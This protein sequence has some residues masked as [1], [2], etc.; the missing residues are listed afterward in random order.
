MK[1]SDKFVSEDF[2]RSTYVKHVAAPLFRKSFNLNGNADTAELVICG[3][4]LY[5]LFVNGQRI[6]E[7]RLA[8][9]ISN[10]DHLIYYNRYDLTQYL[11]EGENVI[12]IMLGD[13][14]QNGKTRVWNFDNNIFNSA[15]KLALW[16]SVTAK[17]K[18][19]VFEADS[20]MCKKG[21]VTFNDIRSGI[22]Y[23]KRLEEE[24]WNSPGYTED[25]GWHSPLLADKPR[26]KA[27]L[28]EAEP[29][30]VTKEL[31]P[32]RIFK[33]GIKKYIPVEQVSEGLEGHITEE[34]APAATG[35]WIYDFGE[36]NAGIFR[37]RIHAAPGQRIDIQCSELIEENCLDYSNIYFFPEGYVQRDIYIA[38]GEG[39]EVYEPMFVYHGFRYLYVSGITEEQATEDLLTYLVMSSDLE[40]RGNFECSD[41][42]SNKI[43]EICRRSDISNFY[44]FPNDCPHREKNGWTGDAAASAEH[45]IMTLGAENSWREWMNNI[46]YSQTIAGD[47]PGIVPTDT[48]GYAWGNG[49]SWD[50][51]I[52]ELPYMVYKY[53]GDAGMIEENAHMMLSY[54][55]YISKK[56][57]EKGIV[58]IGLGD[59]VPAN[60]TMSDYIVP[61]GFTDSVMVYD[62]CRQAE[63]MFQAV[64]YHLHALFAKQLG[65]EMLKAVRSEYIDFNTMTVQSRCQTAQAMAIYYDIF[66]PSEKQA[67]F[68][69]LKSIIHLDEEKITVGF[70]G[71][72]VLFHVLAQF[73]EAELAYKMITRSDELSYG[74][75][76][77]DGETTMI[78]QL[79][80]PERRGKISHNHHFLCD[81]VQWYMRYPG[82]IHVVSVD[83]VKIKPVF[84]R[85]LT[86]VK[87]CHELPSGEVR[88]SWSRT[89]TEIKLCV[90]VPQGIKCTVELDA[91]YI[92]GDIKKSYREASGEGEYAV[93]LTK[94]TKN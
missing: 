40:N 48:F 14:F 28:R 94:K 10:S 50:K 43:Y 29:I 82:G 1:F 32:I 33:G 61:L 31:K 67:A 70:L 69:V 55:E 73:G 62:M 52:F 75:L 78:E 42:L 15:P 74:S 49:P 5:E 25:V 80:A 39:E 24:G 41:E 89:E 51:V 86:Y 17:G 36:N 46:R 79:C 63:E 91:G 6:T 18:T 8:P 68:E 13:G 57:D 21:P 54:L 84:L 92:F 7:S 16:C 60:R 53:R 58:A 76:V 34:T 38:N 47:I 35:G 9:Y 90:R 72:R 23:D 22:F 83:C 30:A 87:A 71:M 77:L 37:L 27:K 12:G 2:M 56:R 64:G 45:M 4:G 85:K 93:V 44:Y 59:W 26:G 20:F 19:T 65:D 81:V 66:S 3:L 88:V 11:T